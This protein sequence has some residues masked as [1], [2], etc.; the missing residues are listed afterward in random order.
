MGI[1]V[2]DDRNYFTPINLYPGIH[3]VLLNP[4]ISLPACG[5]FWVDQAVCVAGWF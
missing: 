5:A 1:L 2:V 3:N 4:A